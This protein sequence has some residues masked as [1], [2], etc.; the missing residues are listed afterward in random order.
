MTFS[1]TGNPASVGSEHIGRRLAREISRVSRGDA[2]KLPGQ[3]TSATDRAI[4]F[5]DRAGWCMVMWQADFAK[6]RLCGMGRGLPRVVS[7]RVASYQ[8]D[9]ISGWRMQMDSLCIV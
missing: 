2:G 8:Q 3:A 5:S 6:D 7:S 9:A 1:V 4:A